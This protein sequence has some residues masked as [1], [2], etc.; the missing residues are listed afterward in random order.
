MKGSAYK[1]VMET[2]LS[3]LLLP[4]GGVGNTQQWPPPRKPIRV[5]PFCLFYFMR[6]DAL[7]ACLEKTTRID[8]FRGAFIFESE[9]DK[10][11]DLC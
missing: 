6:E 5:P 11:E 4:P 10:E 3:C 7:R 8:S 2:A 9:E 1:T